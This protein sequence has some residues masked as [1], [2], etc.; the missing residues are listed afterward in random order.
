MSTNYYLR[1]NYCSECE[2]WDDIHLGQ[3]SQGNK[4]MLQSNGYKYYG[5]WK[6]MQQWLEDHYESEPPNIIYDE[7]G[8]HISIATFFKLV[9]SVQ[10]KQS[11][12]GESRYGYG[13]DPEGYEFLDG[14]FC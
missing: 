4:F 9:K 7:Y 8:T 13:V 3:Y 14:E 10:H 12:H 6:E 2:R 5:N 1:V 11:N